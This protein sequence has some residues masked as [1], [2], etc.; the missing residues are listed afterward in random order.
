MKKVLDKGIEIGKHG[1]K[2]FRIVFICLIRWIGMMVV[3]VFLSLWIFFYSM[4]KIYQL[5]KG[6]EARGFWD[7]FTAFFSDINYS[8]IIIFL[9]QVVMI[10]AYFYV[11]NKYAIQ[12][13]ISLLWE[14]QGSV[15]ITDYVG[16][17]MDY[18]YEKK[19]SLFGG[20]PNR[21]AIQREVIA[22]N[23][24]NHVAGMLQRKTTHY[25]VSKARLGNSSSSLVQQLTTL[26]FN[27]MALLPALWVFYALVGVQVLFILYIYYRF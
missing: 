8:V 2:S 27:P 7:N 10:I 20:K 17:L 19:P 16:Q 12:K 24:H 5:R 15:F 23:D 9:L 4:S 18:L 3:G 6:S 25:V 1:L 11:A 14:K 21:E 13:A 22:L 26:R